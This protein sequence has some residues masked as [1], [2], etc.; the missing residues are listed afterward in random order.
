[1][2]QD[3]NN[4]PVSPIYAI[5]LLWLV[6]AFILP[7]FKLIQY[8]PLIIATVILYKVVENFSNKKRQER[9]NEA[10]AD[11]VKTES[12][13]AETKKEEPVKSKTDLLVEKLIRDRNLAI[14]EMRRL[15]ENIKD[16]KISKQID[17]LELTTTKIFDNVIA[18]PDKREQIGKFLNYY[19]P[20]TLKLLNTYDR[21]S[22]QGVSGDNIQNTM[23]KVEDT[24]EMIVQAFKK[25]LDILFAG[26]ALDVSSDITVMENLMKTEGL[27]DDGMGRFEVEKK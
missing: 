5:I 4:K 20:T 15:N 6:W 21:M 19:L 18:H 13:K 22:S 11:T 9:E 16:D 25:Q 17:T 14:S 10:K 27:A 3:N 24:M 8:I 12:V 26:E 7:L 1:M 2:N 23:K